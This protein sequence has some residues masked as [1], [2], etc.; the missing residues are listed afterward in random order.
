VVR[1]TLS[2]RE[3]E[4]LTL[5]FGLDGSDHRTLEQVSRH[6]GLTRER[7]R[8]IEAKALTKLRLALHDTDLQSA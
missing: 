1:A 8:Q 7:V 4:V 6:F 3:Q 5:R 2:A